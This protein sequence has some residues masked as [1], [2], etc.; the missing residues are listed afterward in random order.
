MLSKKLVQKLDVWDPWK[1]S[2][3]Q[4]MNPFWQKS[5][6]R[7][8]NLDRLRKVALELSMVPI[9]TFPHNSLIFDV[10]VLTHFLKQVSSSLICEHALKCRWRHIS[11]R[12]PKSLNLRGG[13]GESA[14]PSY[15][16]DLHLGA[17][18]QI[19]LFLPCWHYTAIKMRALSVPSPWLFP[20]LLGTLERGG[21]HLWLRVN[22][23]CET[24]ETLRILLPSFAFNPTNNT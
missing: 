13:G 19:V 6:K 7:P 8:L 12:S 23:T 16:G 24:R 2:E 18:V 15:C 3:W 20:T 11:Y 1:M 5:E 9:R 22:G 10:F 14:L 17:V 21:R 4:K